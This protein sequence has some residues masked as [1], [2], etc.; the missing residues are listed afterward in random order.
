MDKQFTLVCRQ[1][2]HRVL[3]AEVDI[4]QKG[5]LSDHRFVSARKNAICLFLSLPAESDL[6]EI[7][8]MRIFSGNL[9]FCPAVV[10]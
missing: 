6:A 5:E 3:A 7:A 8:C 2:P 10:N 9:R 4:S 1:P